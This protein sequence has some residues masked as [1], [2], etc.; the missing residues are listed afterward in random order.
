MILILDLI[1]IIYRYHFHVFDVI[2]SYKS[3]NVGSTYEKALRIVTFHMSR[4]CKRE[5]GRSDTEIQPRT[6]L[7]GAAITCN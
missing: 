5:R 4:V 6:G 2:K 7:S 3:M 1:L